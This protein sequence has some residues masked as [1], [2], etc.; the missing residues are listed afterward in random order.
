MKENEFY[1]IS[2][3]Y[4]HKISQVTKN[5]SYN[6]NSSDFLNARPYYFCM[7]D[8]KI[9][10]IKWI[11]P[12]STKT[13]KYK[14]EH[15]KK[16]KKYGKDYT[17]AFS[18][19][20]STDTAFLLQNMLPTIEDYKSGTYINKN[21]NVPYSLSNAEFLSL[22]KSVSYILMQTF[23]YNNKMTFTNIKDIYS[24]MVNEV[25]LETSKNL[26][27]KLNLA[28]GLQ[29]DLSKVIGLEFYSYMDTNNEN[30]KKFKVND[31]FKYEGNYYLGLEDERKRN[32]LIVNPT[33]NNKTGLL[34][35][36]V[37]VDERQH[38]RTNSQEKT[39][40]SKNDNVME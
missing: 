38:R 15:N 17:I 39:K 11:I 14:E 22:K 24:L 27:G 13:N 6:K 40:Q 25:V 9:P 34:Q 26:Y 33:L 16:I 35:Y 5:V 21:N 12:T 3:D 10:A 1:F 20:N 37:L 19:I 18:T 30:V 29:N 8:K 7:E 32:Y 2:N 23:K 36:P 31:F 4:F 28:K